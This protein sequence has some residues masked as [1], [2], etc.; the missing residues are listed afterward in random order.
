[1]SELGRL[2]HLFGRLHYNRFVTRA[3]ASSMLQKLIRQPRQRQIRLCQDSMLI[4]VTALRTEPCWFPMNISGSVIPRTRL[5][6]I[7][8]K[9]RCIFL[10]LL[11]GV[12]GMCVAIR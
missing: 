8:I 4:S 10:S 6:S 7:G 11:G 12:L 1:M 5:R 2:V 9:M 3:S